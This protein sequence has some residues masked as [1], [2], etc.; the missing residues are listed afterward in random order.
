MSAEKTVQALAAITDEGLFE[1][2]AMAILREANPTY[3]SLVHPGMNVGKTVK[4]PLDG[5]CFVQGADPPHMIA[6]HHTITARS[7]LEKKWL[8]DP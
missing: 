2:L 6:V 5:I 3:R 1:R 7:D 8:H 4:S